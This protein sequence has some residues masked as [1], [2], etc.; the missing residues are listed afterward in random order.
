MKNIIVYCPNQDC[1][2]ILIKEAYLRPGSKFK[3]KCYHCGS[4]SYLR[5]ETG[6]KILTELDEY[7]QTKKKSLTNN[8]NSDTLFLKVD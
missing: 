6:N 3:I 4:A 1:R 2:K 5:G 8:E 7:I